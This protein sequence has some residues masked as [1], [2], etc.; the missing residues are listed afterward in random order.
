[1]VEQVDACGQPRRLG[2]EGRVRQ[3]G[4][5]PRLV[6][7]VG[8]LLVVQRLARIEPHGFAPFGGG[9]LR[10][11]EAVFRDFEFVDV[12]RRL[13]FAE[14]VAAR[15]DAVAQR[16]APYFER[17]VFEER[18]MTGRID[19]VPLHVVGQFAVEIAQVAGENLSER[20]RCIDRQR[21]A[22]AVKPE[23][24]E[25][26]EEPEAVVAVQVREKDGPQPQRIDPVAE[27]LLLRTFPRVDEVVLL[28]EVDDLCRRVSSGR[29]LG[30][31]RTEDGDGETHGCCA[32]CRIGLCG[33][34]LWQRY[35]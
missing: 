29:R 25:Q 28:V 34:I 23:R 7:A 2:R 16:D 32:L 6:G 17:T 35:D 12:Q 33:P 9:D 19:L 22:A 26:R 31:S 27:Q 4:V 8:Q 11:R 15:G 20:G 1:M 14:E 13:L 3:V 5:R 30:R 21:R 10:D 24:R 18:P